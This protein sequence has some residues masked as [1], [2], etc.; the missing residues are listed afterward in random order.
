MHE[1][2]LAVSLIEGASTEARGR[3]ATKVHSLTVRAGV[4]TGV[5]PELLLRAYEM[6]RTGTF[7]EGAELV[8]E[9]E[10]ARASCPSCGAESEFED[11]YLVCPSCGGIGLKPLSGD[12][13][14]LTKM[15]IEVPETKEI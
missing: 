11:F 14:A 8:L 7:L 9:V 6:A 3:G 5:V 2:S 4:L 15:D 12:G 13:L 10:P 1:W